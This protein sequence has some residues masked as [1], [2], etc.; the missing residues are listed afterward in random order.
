MH[1]HTLV[2]DFHVGPQ[3]VALIDIP[4]TNDYHIANELRYRRRGLSS[5]KR[6]VYNPF[7]FYHIQKKP[8]FW[9][10]SLFQNSCLRYRYIVSVELSNKE[11]LVLLSY[12]NVRSALGS[13]IAPA[14]DCVCHCFSTDMSEHVFDKPII[15]IPVSLFSLNSLA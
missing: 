9:T 14:G 3:N 8:S 7:Y 12:P 13:I 1:S 11:A 4:G 6:L 2:I 10:A 5:H 15:E